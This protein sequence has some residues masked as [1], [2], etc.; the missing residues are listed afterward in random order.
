METALT[1]LTPILLG[2]CVGF[3]LSLTG[4]GGAILS[5]PLLVFGMHLTILEASPIGLLAVFLS[6]GIGALLG[7]R[8]KILRY[9]A[10]G[11]M[12]LF[13][14]VLSPIGVFLAHQLP[15]QPLMLIFSV[16]LLYAS[17][18]ILIQSYREFKGI[19]QAAVKPPPCVL[20]TNIGKLI[21]NVPCARSLAMAGSIAGFFS[22]LLGVGGGFVIVP[23]LKTVTDLPQKSIV[24]TSLGV[25][26]L[27]SLSGVISAVVSGNMLWLI[28][29]PFSMGSLAGMLM[30]RFFAKKLAG[31]VL[32]ILFAI[33]A[34]GVAIL[35]AYKG[36]N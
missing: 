4:A 28:A 20:D 33:F 11:L 24:A 12:A 31:P 25:L 34:F 2:L 32:Q 22:G 3:I 26:T 18:R 6:A 30:G 19:A 16:V 13:G 1:E 9:K 14:T 29:L 36:F 7:F 5:V 35:M 27:V 23:A 10:A 8:E 17:S 15:N 21:W